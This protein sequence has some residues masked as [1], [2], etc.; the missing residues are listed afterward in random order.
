MAT[1][2]ALF[3]DLPYWLSLT[4]GVPGVGP[5]LT[6]RLILHFG[7]GEAVFKATPL[8]LK[9]ASIPLAAVEAIGRFKEFDEWKS[10]V[11]ILQKKSV[12][13]VVFTD[14]IY[15]KRLKEIPGYPPVL[16]VWGDIDCLNRGEWLGVV[17][18]RD[19]TEYGVKSCRELVGP[20]AAAGLGIISGFALGVDI[21]AHLATL[22][23]GGK[24]VG[25][26]GGGFGPLSPSSHRRHIPAIIEK[27]GALI[28]EF[29]YS[30][31]PIPK[32]F[33]RRNRIISGLSRGVLVIEANEKSGAMITARY[34]LDQNRDLFAVPGPIQ[35]DK[36]RGCNRLIQ[37]GAK[38]VMEPEDVLKEWK[39]TAAAKIQIP[40]DH[41]D[42]GSIYQACLNAGLT[43][44]EIIEQ[45]GIAAPSVTMFLTKLELNGRLQCM[46]GRR[47]RS[48]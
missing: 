40:F 47:Y 24:T 39:M 17:G 6:A 3:A 14:P 31:V 33:P 34:A 10:E 35:S 22:E 15:P 36:S 46:P 48:L 27:G 26:L 2:A 41:P 25:V 23:A 28:S 1:S 32:F 44:D 9:E 37:E 18:S 20:L 4:F 5:A 29:P 43:A 21:T 12:I 30:M 13:S 8:A 7:S 42:E 38:L 16:F 45:T 19:L 11:A